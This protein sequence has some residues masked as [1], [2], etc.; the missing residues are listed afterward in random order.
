MKYFEAK[1]DYHFLDYKFKNTR[2][3]NLNKDYDCIQLSAS[4]SFFRFSSIKIRKF[5]ANIFSWEDVKFISIISII[6]FSYNE[7]C[8]L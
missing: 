1:S 7:Y 6:K 2:I 3:V 5:E 8:L 4:R